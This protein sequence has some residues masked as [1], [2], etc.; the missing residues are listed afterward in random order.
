M[1]ERV[2]ACECVHVIVCAQE[3]TYVTVC[4]CECAFPHV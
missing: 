3:N 4:M 1:C 2:C